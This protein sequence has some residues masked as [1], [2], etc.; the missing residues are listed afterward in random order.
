MTI[1]KVGRRTIPVRVTINHEEETIWSM[2]ISIASEDN[3]QQHH[4]LET[5]YD[6]KSAS[7]SGF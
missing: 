7:R 2:P 5:F 4:E 6:F 1:H 3:E